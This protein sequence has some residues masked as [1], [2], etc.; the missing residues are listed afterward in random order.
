M[1]SKV[2]AIPDSTA[3]NAI[4]PWA[5]T[6]ARRRLIDNVYVLPLPPQAFKQKILPLELLTES[7]AVSKTCRCWSL[8]VLYYSVTFSCRYDALYV[9]SSRITL[10]V[11][12]CIL[13]VGCGVGKP[14][15]SCKSSP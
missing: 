14:K 10:G 13:D 3:P 8:S 1:S 5:L 15:S 7:I 12:L 9:V 4:L 11:L 2:A 6:A